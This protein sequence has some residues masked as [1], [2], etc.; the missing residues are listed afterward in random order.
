VNA[1]PVE[2]SPTLVAKNIEI[3]TNADGPALNPPA[4]PAGQSIW[5]RFR[6]LGM[7]ADEKGQV[8]LTE[9]WAVL[10]P[11][12]KPAFQQTDTIVNGQ[13]V[14]PPLFVP[15][16]DHLDVSS[17]TPPGDYKFQVVLH[18]K[19]ANTDFNFEQPFTISKP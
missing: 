13:F 7:K 16:N 5:L 10:G 11:D 8:S 15:F 19:V 14:Y 6:V 9:D 17:G 2:T 1:P 3:S 18:D 12:S 4:F